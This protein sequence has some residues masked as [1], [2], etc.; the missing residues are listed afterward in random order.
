MEI[1]KAREGPARSNQRQNEDDVIAAYKW[2]VCCLYL[3][4]GIIL[5]VNLA[6]RLE[7]NAALM[8]TGG[9]EAAGRQLILAVRILWK[10]IF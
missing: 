4:T 7:A 10:I 2:L 8:E 1:W 5:Q 3:A 9:G 6:Q